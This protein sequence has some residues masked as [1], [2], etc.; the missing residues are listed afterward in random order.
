MEEWIGSG[1]GFW[2]KGLRFRVSKLCL[3]KRSFFR[4][5][6]APKPP[7]RPHRVSDLPALRIFKCQ[8]SGV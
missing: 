1:L 5:A 8:A 2:L 6:E 3:L 4:S 7:D